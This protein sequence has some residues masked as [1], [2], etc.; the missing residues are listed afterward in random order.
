MNEKRA[1]AGEWYLEQTTA[2]GVY[3]QGASNEGVLDLSGNIWEWCLN[4]YDRPDE[5]ETNTSGHERV[6]RGGS[7]NYN[8]GVAR[9]ALRFRSGPGD[10]IG[11]VG[12]RLVSSASIA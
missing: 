6:V 8:P 12:I 3:P 5:I 9:G 1:D 11:S 7:W 2:V 4:E 10:R